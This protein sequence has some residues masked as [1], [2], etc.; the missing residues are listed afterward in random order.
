LSDDRSPTGLFTI[1]DSRFTIEAKALDCV[2]LV[3]NTKRHIIAIFLCCLVMLPLLFSGGLQIFQL[4]LKQRA[5]YRME[6]GQ[7]QNLVIPIEKVQWMEEGREI[8]VDGKMFDL[9][10]YSVEDGFL[11]ARG[12]FDE[13]ETTVVNLLHH[14][15]EKAQSQLI[16]R[17]LLFSQC[18]VILAFIAHA[19]HLPSIVARKTGFIPPRYTNLPFAPLERPP[20]VFSFSLSF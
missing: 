18:L 10:S 3:R 14:F 19:L 11:K 12:V 8:M 1:D 20:G 16:I 5:S 2:R 13:R 17:L 6:H 4:Y 15:N 9:A 7:M